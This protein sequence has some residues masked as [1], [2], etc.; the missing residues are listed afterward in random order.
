VF[1]ATNPGDPQ[2][3]HHVGMY[4]GK[5]LMVHAPRTGDV[6]RTASVWRDDYAGAV[7]PVQAAR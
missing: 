4:I 3:I 2:T 7:R 5:G 1:F 6:V